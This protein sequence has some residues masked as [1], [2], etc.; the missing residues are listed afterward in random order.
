MVWTSLTFIG[1]WS[2]QNACA[3]CLLMVPPMMRRSNGHLCNAGSSWSPQDGISRPVHGNCCVRQI[4]FPRAAPRLPTSLACI[5]LG[6]TCLHLCFQLS[7]WK[8]ICH[9]MAPL[10][11]SLILGLCHSTRTL[12]H[13]AGTILLQ[14]LAR[15]HPRSSRKIAGLLQRSPKEQA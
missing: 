3:M 14:G 1:N 8:C 10:C 13:H 4:L 5:L 15:L 11:A 2:T 7:S 12:L 9:S 6:G